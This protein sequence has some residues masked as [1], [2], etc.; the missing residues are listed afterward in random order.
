MT[1]LA[2][3][4]IAGTALLT[5]SASLAC[6]QQSNDVS[7]I[8]NGQV[9][10][11]SDVSKL[12]TTIDSVAGNVNSS[13]V[14]GGNNVSVFTMNNTNVIN[15]QYVGPSADIVAIQNADVENAGGT[16]TLQAQAIC[17][18][19]DI[20]TDPSNVNVKSSQVCDATDPYAQLNANVVNAGND[21]ALAATAVGNTFSEDT[22]APNANVTTRQVNNSMEESVVNSTITQVSG[23]VTVNSSAI[24]NNAQIVHY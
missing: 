5:L 7:N 24:G 16:V 2:R 17:N 8:L 10:L 15:K 19:A 4:L 6:A 3:I 14:A 20:S 13:S 11:Q 21:T 12:N 22:N 1:R 18:G 9:N 23:N